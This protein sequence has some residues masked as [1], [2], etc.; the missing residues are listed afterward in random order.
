MS[1]MSEKFAKAV[2]MVGVERVAQNEQWGGAEHDA[3]N[4]VDDWLNYIGKQINYVWGKPD[5]PD[6][7]ERFVKIA[8][9]AFAAIEAMSDKK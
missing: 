6:T 1:Q 9:L 5:S 4:T 2:A 8:A 3:C 7:V